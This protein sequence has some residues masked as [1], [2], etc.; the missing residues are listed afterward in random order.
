[1]P[2]VRIQ[3]GSSRNPDT[4]K[5]SLSLRFRKEYGAGK[6]DYPLFADAPSGDTAVAE[7]DFLQLRCGYNFG[8]IHRHYY[9]ARHAQSN[10]DQWVN[11][12]FLA[13][14]QPGSHGRWVHLY[15]N[16]IYWGIYHAHER[17]DADFM[18]SYFGGTSDD[19]DALNSGSAVNGDKAAWNTM[20]A[21]ANG[22]IADP[23][24]Y[25]EHPAI[26]R[27]RLAHRLHARE[28]LRRQPRLG[29]PQLAGRPEAR[30][31]GRIQVLPVGLGVR[32]LAEQLRVVNSP[33]PLTNALGDRRQRQE[34]LGPPDRPAPRSHRQRRNT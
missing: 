29:R 33:Q 5:H 20:V 1:M 30:G 12:L 32:D 21:I 17:P 2:A 34:H 11:D 25:A 18:A 31:R 3:G 23:A 13:M 27:C 28:L 14:G 9:Q 15:I 4:P 16:G 10:R 8:W 7:F 19:Y 26:P 22:N 24:Q 6:L